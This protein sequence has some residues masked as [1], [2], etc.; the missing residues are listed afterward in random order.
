MGICRL[1]L[2]GVTMAACRSLPVYPCE[3]K[4]QTVPACLTRA[5]SGLPHRSSLVLCNEFKHLLIEGLGVLNL[6]L[7]RCRRNRCTF[8][9]W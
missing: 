8:D 6:H 5:N 1:Q 2:N 9:A 3:R 7:M 4:R